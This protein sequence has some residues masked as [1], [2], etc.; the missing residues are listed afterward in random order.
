M[1]IF[2]RETWPVTQRNEQTPPPYAIPF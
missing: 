1:R 2:F